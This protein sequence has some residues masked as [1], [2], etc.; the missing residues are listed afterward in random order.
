MTIGYH[1]L[2]VEDDRLIAQLIGSALAKS[3]YHISHVTDGVA[4]LE[5][6]EATQPD[7]I[8]LDIYL[9]LLNGWEFLEKIQEL[10]Q[11]AVPIIALSATELE[12]PMP[13]NVSS[14]FLKPFRMARLIETINQI[15]PPTPVNVETQQA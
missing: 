2:L 3:G 5:H 15:L 10:S 6:L 14:F 7:L 1:I 12:H 8:L 4:A 13:D 11:S 9:P